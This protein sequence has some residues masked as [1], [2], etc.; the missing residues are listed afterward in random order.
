MK[1]SRFPAVLAQRMLS[2]RLPQGGHREATDECPL[3]VIADI[4]C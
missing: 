3:P 2:G 4:E 1:L